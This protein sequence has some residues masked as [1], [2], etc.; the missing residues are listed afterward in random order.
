MKN[1][2]IALLMLF[3]A[4]FGFAQ[5]PIN[6]E[7]G[8]LGAD[9]TWTTAE[10]GTNP[11]LEIVDNPFKTGINTSD[12]V[13][14]FTA[15]QAG[16]QW[17]LCHSSNL[18]SLTFTAD[19]SKVKI[20]VYK[21]VI[22]DFGLKFEAPG[23]NKEIKVAN[24]KINE[25]EELTFDFSSVIGITYTT[26]VVIPDFTARA[27]DNVIYFDNIT[28]NAGT[29]ITPVELKTID[30]ET[31]GVGADWT[32][33]MAENGT[34]PP[35]EMVDN[36]FKTGINTSAKV[37]KFT[38][39]DA[40]Q[41][42]A[43]C[44]SDGIGTFKLDDKNSIVKVMV[45]KTVISDFA[46]KFEGGSPAKEIKVA[47]T[48]INEWEEITIDFS[49]VKGSTYDK[50]V[51]IPDFGART[52]DNVVLID[53]IS[54]NAPAPVS[55][56]L[57]TIDFETAGVGADWTWTV[58]ENGTD[59]AL[60][61]VDN[62]SKTGI[63]TTD[64]VAKFTALQAGQMWAL[65]FSTNIGAF[66]FD[67][68]TS[69]VK[70]MVY[71]TVI[72][73]VAIKFEG[74][75]GAKEIKVPNT[76]INE[77]EELTFDFSSVIGTT[78]DKIVI[79][80]DFASRTADNVV[81]I[82][83][84]SFNEPTPIVND[85]KTID[86]EAGGVG[87]DWTWTVD[88]NGD[89]P[90]LTFVANPAKAGINTSEKVAMFTAK[91]AGQDWALFHSADIK[92]F[93]FDET[94]CFVKV[95]VY[96]TVISNVGVK[97]EGSSDAKEILVANTKVNEWEE[98]IFD[99]SGVKGNSYNRIVV[100]PDFAARSTDNV[101]YLDN[102]SFNAPAPVVNPLKTVDFETGGVGA[103]WVWTVAANGDNPAVTVVTNPS[104]T[105]IN[106]SEKVAM[107]T[108]KD[109][110]DDWALFHS[111]DIQTFV[112]D[113]TNCFVRI[114][115]HKTVLSDVGLKF[116]GS[117]AALE[118]KVKN[119]K[120]NEW[121]EIVFDFSSVKGN[122][123]NRIVI[124]PDFAARS[125]D[126]VIYLDNISFGTAPVAKS[127]DATLKELKVDGTAVAGFSAA[128]LTYNMEL[129]AGTTTVPT[130]TAMANHDKASVL[131]T[132]ATALPGATTILV[133]A[134]D[135]T[136]QTYTINF[137][138]AVPKSNDATLS[139]LTVNGTSV[140]NFSASTLTYAVK[141]PVGTTAVPTVV[142]T[143]NDAK[144]TVNITYP[145]ALPGTVTILVTAEDGS[146]KTY[147]IELTVTPT[148]VANNYADLIKMY[149]AEK[150]VYM[151]FPSELQNGNVEIMDATGRVILKG[152]IQATAQQFEV[153]TSGIVIVRIT[154]SNNNS[155]KNTKLYVK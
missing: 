99:F 93:V 71:K 87:A 42:W 5:N 143:A 57:K 88:Q 72:S 40:G 24:T 149:S 8:G 109:A 118:L 33:T 55:N 29:V 108:A 63:N 11:A 58:G 136:T 43:L 107:F 105:G 50:I 75:S 145:T 22:S 37:A 64:K 86:F 106:T 77:W 27:A 123:Y 122:S 100:I 3:M 141:L 146:T 2:T 26:V 59:P 62:P 32:W 45:Y 68:K 80:P 125:T 147:T 153:K 150:L 133:T 91:D 129:A 13:A 134:E 74:G 60:E 69:F 104:K 67:D 126:N 54:F 46:V 78:Y 12:K 130:V 92:A 101:V 14:K 76:K 137:T 84:I 10:N 152:K 49:S 114:M 151:E 116:E 1:F 132:P 35:L 7:T 112:F 48:K 34:N 96:K 36:P 140:D 155:V 154:D 17:A 70:V 110:G 94:N 85:L 102:I 127:N 31:P 98:L 103:D 66:K 38:A 6:F 16:Q 115:V 128:T 139:A 121:E 52:A 39:T 9:W 117:S 97:F 81:L 4:S 90:A 73:D 135:G 51:L 111:G 41:D 124:I 53:N 25:W 20:W 21:T 144:A 79:I 113:E 30:F 131:V 61:I 83:N 119:T 142:A 44:F 18:G 95:M 47:N 56:E 28:F 82:D 89:N 138:V 23:V 19:N 120:V 65:F 15:L 148:S